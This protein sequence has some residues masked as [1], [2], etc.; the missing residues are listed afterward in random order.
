MPLRKIPNFFFFF[1]HQWISTDDEISQKGTED[2]LIFM[3][4]VSSV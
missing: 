4:F 2:K 3:N 1:L